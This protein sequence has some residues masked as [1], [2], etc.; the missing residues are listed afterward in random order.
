MLRFLPMLL[1][2][3]STTLLSQ[4]EYSAVIEINGLSQDDLFNKGKEWLF[5]TYN[6][7]KEVLQYENRESGEIL[8]SGATGTVY[9]KNITN[10]DAG[11]FRYKVRLGFKDGRTRIKLEDIIYH[12]GELKYKDGASYYDEYPSNWP[13]SFRKKNEREWNR[14]K[15]Q[16]HIE[17]STVVKS[18]VDFM[19]T[20][21]SSDEDW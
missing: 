19:K 16:A 15:D 12:K 5:R 17:L 7:G 8:G 2:F 3:I 10:V 20:S 14:M 11:Y 13:T 1:L 9:Y 18:F 4:E 6:E 21:S